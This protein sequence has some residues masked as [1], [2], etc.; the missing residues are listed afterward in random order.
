[1]EARDRAQR[2]RWLVAAVTVAIVAACSPPARNDSESGAE[3]YTT[4]A[5]VVEPTGSPE[6]PA[7]TRETP[8]SVN[9]PSL[10]IGSSDSFSDGSLDAACLQLSWL[11][12]PSLPSGFSVKITGMQFSKVNDQTIFKIV[13]TKCQ[14]RS[15]AC[16]KSYRY[17]PDHASCYI[18]VAPLRFRMDGFNGAELKISGRLDCPLGDKSACNLYASQVKQNFE[19][20]IFELPYPPDVPPTP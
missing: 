1:M 10:P 16:G 18:T 14:D 12:N 19:P 5:P 8:P 2:I 9:L 7:P 6:P 15:P 13:D 20:L 4:N 11:G 17:T 3:G